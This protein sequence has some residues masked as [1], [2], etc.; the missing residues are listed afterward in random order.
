MSRQ[1]TYDYYE[2]SI[3]GDVCD[4]GTMTDE[5]SLEYMADMAI[6]EARENA[7]LY[8]IPA[9]WTAERISGELGDWEVIFKVRRKR[10]RQTA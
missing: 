6:N 4:G 8:C 3:P 9:E 1:F 2:I 5:E 10:F 7:K